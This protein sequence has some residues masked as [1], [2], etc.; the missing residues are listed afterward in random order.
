ML[1]CGA[2]LPERQEEQVTVNGLGWTVRDSGAGYRWT[3][4]DLPVPVAVEV[5]DAYENPAEL[6]N[7]LAEPLLEVLGG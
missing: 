2:A 7:P 5:P 1:E 3:T 4:R 6:V